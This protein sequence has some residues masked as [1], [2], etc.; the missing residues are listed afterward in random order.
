MVFAV[1]RVGVNGY[2]FEV[3]PARKR[4]GGRRGLI[5]CIDPESYSE[6]VADKLRRFAEFV[7]FRL[8]V[9]VRN[10]ES[11]FEIGILIFRSEI[12]FRGVSEHE[13]AVLYRKGRRTHRRSL[14]L[15]R[16]YVCVITVFEGLDV[17]DRFGRVVFITYNFGVV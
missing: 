8:V 7:E 1:R 17:I 4:D 16:E 9:Q 11:K 15:R 10:I 13:F 3:K 6:P 12:S 2:A 14:A 5:Y